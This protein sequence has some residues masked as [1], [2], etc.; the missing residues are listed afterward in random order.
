MTYPLLVSEWWA[1]VISDGSTIDFPPE[2]YCDPRAARR[3]A[4]RWA[5]TLTLGS[6]PVVRRSDEVLSVG[7]RDVMVRPV[8]RDA[9]SPRPWILAFAAGPISGGAHIQVA[10]R[11]ES[12]WMVSQWAQRHATQVERR[13][14]TVRAE[15]NGAWADAQLAK[16]CDG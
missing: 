5:I 1:L 4:Y 3:E 8:H 6:V 13:H 16:I 15:S 12:I 9:G 2:L 14:L 7:I 11:A 10:S